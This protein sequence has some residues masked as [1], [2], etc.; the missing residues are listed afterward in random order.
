MMA[1]GRGD[2]AEGAGEMPKEPKR[3]DAATKA[4][5]AGIVVGID[6][7][8]TKTALMATAVAT[9]EDLGHHR[10]PTPADEGPD[11]M[12][13][14]VIA[15]IHELIA[16]AGRTPRD[17]RAV[18]VAVPGQVVREAGRIIE[19]GNLTGW[20][21]VPLRDMVSRALAVPVWVDHDANAA[22]LGERWRG[23]ARTMN[24]YVF[25]A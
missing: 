6:V 16:A 12:V 7:G 21:D 20:T 15:G 8:G 3:G 4:N 22:A 9:G 1:P 10:F 24:N 2:A 18:G 19:A 5:E 13:A 17:L 23:G 25:L 11:R 14:D